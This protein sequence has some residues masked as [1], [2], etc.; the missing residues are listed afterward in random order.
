M[1]RE[2]GVSTAQEL[3]QCCV[4]GASV[5]HGSGVHGRERGVSTARELRHCCVGGASAPRGSCV[6]AV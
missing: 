1:L 5:L 4:R 6:I 3:C 2:R